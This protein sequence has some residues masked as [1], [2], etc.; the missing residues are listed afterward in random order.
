MVEPLVAAAFTGGAG[1]D[2]RIGWRNCSSRAAAADEVGGGGG[3]ANRGEAAGRRLERGRRWPAEPRRRH[4]GLDE[5]GNQAGGGRGGDCGS[6]ARWCTDLGGMLIRTVSRGLRPGRHAAAER[7]MRTVSF[8]GPSGSLM[9]SGN[10]LK[11]LLNPA[12][13]SLVN[14]RFR[15]EKSPE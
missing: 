6:R 2:G 13:L 15:R 14:L 1:S 4:G 5:R 9:T 10:S 11:T 3:W 12:N 8:L 7:V